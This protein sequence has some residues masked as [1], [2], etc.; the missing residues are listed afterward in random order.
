[1]SKY[2]LQFLIQELQP[3][4][5]IKNRI[6]ECVSWIIENNHYRV[7]SILEQNLDRWAIPYSSYK[8]WKDYV[9]DSILVLVKYWFIKNLTYSID[10]IPLDIYSPDDRD[11][12]RLI[13]SF[14]G[15]NYT[16]I[17]RGTKE[18][19]EQMLLNVKSSPSLYYFEV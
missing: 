6:D 7:V 14:D 19:C 2:I 17:Q 16:I 3:N 5:Q 11:E 15:L 12:Y 9:S 8:E 4:L 18:R 13:I 1:M 10:L